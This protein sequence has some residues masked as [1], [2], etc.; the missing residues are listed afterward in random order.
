M[1]HAFIWEQRKLYPKAN[2]SRIVSDI[3][4][5]RIYLKLLDDLAGSLALKFISNKYFS[6]KTIKL[7]HEL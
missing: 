5:Y 6:S 2:K 3:I 7:S 1:S 4:R